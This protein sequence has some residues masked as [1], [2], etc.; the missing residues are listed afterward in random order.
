VANQFRR[1]AGVMS[2]VAGLAAGCGVSDAG[3]R[4]G[5]VRPAVTSVPSGTSDPQARRAVLAYERFLLAVSRAQQKP[6]PDSSRYPDSADF[7]QYSF[8][9]IESEYEARLQVLI[10]DGAHFRGP[11][12][13]P[14]LTV[15]AI[16]PDMSPW[17]TVTLSDCQTGLDRWQA[18]DAR[19]GKPVA[20]QDPMVPRPY[21]AK[22]TVVYK[23]QTWGVRTITMDPD[24]TCPD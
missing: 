2:L 3:S 20:R 6:M 15:T 7:G 13:T 19:T 10:K 4:A 12:P 21:G 14:H 9:P 11:R 24:R 22:I 1:Q 17:P 5:L 23:L 18:V 16:D 8:D